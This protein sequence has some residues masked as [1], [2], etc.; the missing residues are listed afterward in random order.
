[1]YGG[2]GGALATSTDAITWTARTSGTSNNINSIIYVNGIY[3]YAGDGGVLRTSTDA[4]TWTASTSGTTSWIQ[5]ITYGNG[6]Y[7]YVGL[8]AAIATS[9]NPT[10]PQFSNQYNASTEFLLPGQTNPTTLVTNTGGTQQ[11]VLSVYVKA[12]P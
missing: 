1:M 11:G 2:V 7:V 4:I 5:S 6:L 8:G 12:K 9:T 3:V 10:I